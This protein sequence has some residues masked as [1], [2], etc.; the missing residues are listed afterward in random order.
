MSM[1]RIVTV[2]AATAFIG[3]LALCS[4][5]SVGEPVARASYIVQARDVTAAHVA[6]AGIRVAPDRDL[7]IIRATT[8]SLTASQAARLR[9]DRSV[10]VYA[11]LEVRASGIVPVSLDQLLKDFT[12]RTNMVVSSS[13]VGGLTSTT[14]FA[15]TPVLG[16]SLLRSVT[17]PVAGA[18]SSSATLRDGRGVSALGLVYE[19][20]YPGLIGADQLHDRG[21]T[22][23]SVSIAVLDS[24]LWQDTSQNYGGRIRATVD[25]VNGGRG[26]VNGDQYGHGTHITSIAASGAITLTGRYQGIAP[27]ADLVIVRAFDRYG[28]GRYT[29]VIAGLDW[30]VKNRDR[31]NIRV[32]N[33][34]FG[35]QPQSF[36][37]DDPLN[38]AV[39]QAWRA[40][41]VVVVSS[42]ND[43]PTPMTVNVPGN[44]PYVITVGAMT[45]SYTP[46]N[47]SD[48]VLATFSSSGPT[49][50][51]FVKPEIVAPGGHI[52]ASMS[53]S[54]YL[55]NLDPGSMQLGQ[56]LFTMSGTSQAAAVTTGVVALLLHNEP[57][58]TPDEVKCRLIR[59]ARP[60][61]TGN[62]KLAYSVFQQ[63]AGLINAASAAGS[64]GR[65]NC[66]NSG[67]DIHADLAGTRHFGGPANRD[68]NGN[69]YIMEMGDQWGAASGN[70]GESW[71]QG[72]GDDGYKWSAGYNWSEGYAWG[73]GY[74][75]TKG[76]AVRTKNVSW[77]E[78][79]TWN[80]GIEWWR[81][82]PR[83]PA[84]TSPASIAN[85]VPNE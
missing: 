10:R 9:R 29:D 47:A 35:A 33:L 26:A 64:R 28:A 76:S 46:N 81:A 31:H 78:G 73:R 49:Y 52:A 62:N 40:G 66:A 13:A 70:D 71:D 14:S 61:V 82:P 20:N 72:Y 55:A 22:G 4:T 80:R 2:T 12:N 83:T 39:M 41:I 38:Q 60:A 43:G 3:V 84:A 25:V 69:F 24:G 19:T 56:Q 57:W 68:A 65:D 23:A 54:T 59:T 5:R 36:Y 37:W 1:P 16:I 11:D 27:R 44:V 18:L 32:L 6:L 45:D 15:V 58:L 63:G 51:G 7:P 21:I 8:A 42:G 53:S 77:S 34:S 17:T 79:Y 75:W 30:V 85:W 67:L 74:P 48:D 50:E